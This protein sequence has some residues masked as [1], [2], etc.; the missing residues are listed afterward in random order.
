M[1]NL[2]KGLKLISIVILLLV[3]AILIFFGHRDIPVEE[4]KSKYA[5]SESSFIAL[6]GVNVHFRDEGNQNDS[7]PIVLLHGTASS[8]HT[9]DAWTNELKKTNRVVRLD[10][11]AYGLTGPF[12]DGQFSRG[13]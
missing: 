5:N 2:I 3:I 6:D 12:P 1:K 13:Q 10:L 11:P 9:F 4:L 8:L 7:I